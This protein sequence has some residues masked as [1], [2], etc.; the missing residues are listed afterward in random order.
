MRENKNIE[1]IYVRLDHLA[2]MAATN[3]DTDFESLSIEHASLKEKIAHLNLQIKLYT[4]TEEDF[5]IAKNK[6]QIRLSTTIAEI[7][8]VTSKLNQ[9]E[10]KLAELKNELLEINKEEELLNQTK[11]TLLER[12]NTYN[13]YAPNKREFNAF[14]SEDSKD[15]ENLE[16]SLKNIA[17]QKQKLHN[18]I[19]YLSEEKTALE[20]TLKALQEKSQN[21]EH[22]I[23]SNKE[24]ED[25]KIIRDKKTLQQEYIKEK[26]AL[27]K[28]LKEI[29]QTPVYLVFKIKSLI[30][31]KKGYEK[32][33][34]MLDKIANIINDIPYMSTIIR[35]NNTKALEDEYETKVKQLAQMERKIKRGSYALKE[36]PAESARITSLSNEITFYQGLITNY[37]EQMQKCEKEITAL[38]S[39]VRSLQENFKVNQ[40]DVE[41]FISSINLLES[42]K[43]Q[44]KLQKEAKRMQ[45]VL[46]IESTSIDATKSDIASLIKLFNQYQ[47]QITICKQTIKDLEKEQNNIKV[48]QLRRHNYIDVIRKN[49]DIEQKNKLEQD[50]FYLENRLK[51][52]NF[53]ALSLLGSIK[54]ALKNYYQIKP[55][56]NVISKKETIEPKVFEA[57]RENVATLPELLEEQLGK[58]I[59]SAPKI[60]QE[61][62]K[63]SIDD[64]ENTLAEL[65]SI[66]E[67]KNSDQMNIEPQ[68]DSENISDIIKSFT[69]DNNKEKL[70]TDNFTNNQFDIDMNEIAQKME[71]KKPAIPKIHFEFEEIKVP[72]A[73][74]KKVPQKPSSSKLKVVAIEKIKKEAN[75]PVMPVGKIK[76]VSVEPL[77]KKQELP[78]TNVDSKPKTIEDIFNAVYNPFMPQSQEEQ[79]LKKV[80]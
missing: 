62:I 5:K 16:N 32:I 55:A 49:K 53:N 12:K 51:Y 65:T 14:I 68:V 21:L 26:E 39:Q 13:S 59:Q 66:F 48:S 63:A 75:K 77:I 60:S 50:I 35:N 58:N 22:K 15:L 79:T 73:T 57:K 25:A 61:E 8:E 11:P 54:T 17:L 52:Q 67:N 30:E 28:R 33:L 70:E 18:A 3:S 80:A 74:E 37:E 4:S 41:E 56:E 27:E 10:E 47:E 2:A 19:N 36:L 34:K 40:T 23:S 20:T 9:L 7:E 46:T 29:E 24:Y 76:V 45:N 69:Q 44:A 64:V 43:E 42:S 1:A 38:V 6:D 78:K 72:T 71:V 31:N